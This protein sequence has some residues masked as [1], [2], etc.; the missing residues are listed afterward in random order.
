MT[1]EGRIPGP[2]SDDDDGWM[3]YASPPAE[4]DLENVLRGEI[5][6]PDEQRLHELVV[7]LRSDASRHGPPAMGPAL[8]VELAQAR[9]ASERSV[10]PRWKVVVAAVGGLVFSGVALGVAGAQGALP[11]P[12]QDATA[13]A[14]GWIGLDLPHATTDARERDDVRTGDDS[15]DNGQSTPGAEDRGGS[16]SSTPGGAI[17]AD[18]GTPG[19]HE[20]ATPATPATPTTGNA[21]RG[22]TGNDNG[23]GANNGNGPGTNQGNDPAANDGNVNANGAGNADGRAT[24]STTPAHR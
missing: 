17:P 5:R 11:D 22:E 15:S 9:A 13:S 21:A 12:V 14:A 8:R 18:P 16:P 6:S 10:L 2:A 7:A 3:T 4:I 24:T 23:P 20:P 1:P 19:D